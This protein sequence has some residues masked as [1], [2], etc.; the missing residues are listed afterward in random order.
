MD[1][2]GSALPLFGT[3]PSY[4]WDF[5][6]DEDE[7]EELQPLLPI[8][9][10]ATS[11]AGY[12]AHVQYQT[13]SN[14]EFPDQTF[15][16]PFDPHRFAGTVQPVTSSPTMMAAAHTLLQNGHHRNHSV[17]DNN[18]SSGQFDHYLRSNAHLNSM[19]KGSIPFDQRDFA[20]NTTHFY[21]NG[22]LGPYMAGSN[23]GMRKLAQTPGGAFFNDRLAVTPNNALYSPSAFDRKESMTHEVGSLLHFGSDGN[24]ANNGFMPPANLETEDHVTDK[25]LQSLD[26][27]QVQP[28]ATNT[29]PAS[30]VM[31]KS[32]TQSGAPNGK[33]KL[34]V[35]VNDAAEKQ[36]KSKPKGKKRRKTKAGAKADEM[37][38]IGGQ[39]DWDEPKQPRSKRQK[40]TPTTNGASAKR[41][42][43]SKAKT[44][45]PKSQPAQSADS[46]SGRENL[47]DE[48][49]RE[50]HIHSEQ[51]RRNTIK[52]GYNE[53]IDFVPGLT[54]GGF[55]RSASLTQA[56]DWL[57]ELS[58][59]NVQLRKQLARLQQGV[60][61]RV[62]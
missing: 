59:N 46:K 7:D 3:D 30:P 56:V 34:P 57:K 47:T 61:S 17:H 42:K 39:D 6:L 18:I 53:L 51:K 35:P 43:G 40:V 60:G 58:N 4:P 24:F 9:T 20:S 13:A 2:G 54:A 19:R 44:Q 14:M 33:T 26:S 55:S 50:N 36:V 31:P 49:R 37:A 12:P 27:F 10:E 11:S 1:R 52:D 16:N 21:G 8:F 32:K 25:M 41:S 15:A 38:V 29:Q 22:S 23:T 45:K 5:P 48:Q 62:A 28:S